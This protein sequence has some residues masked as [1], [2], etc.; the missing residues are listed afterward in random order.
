MTSSQRRDDR[1][2]P[3]PRRVAIVHALPLELYPPVTN[4]LDC[5]GTHGGLACEVFTSHNRAGRPA[6][7]SRHARIHR[8]PSLRT[9]AGPLA[10]LWTPLRFT[11][12]TT[13]ALIRFRPDAILYYEPHSA[14]PV[15]L[16]SRYV[17]PGARLLIHHHEYYEPDQFENPGMR[18][19][20]ASHRLEL[21][22]LFRKADWVSQTNIDRVALMQRDCPFL[23]PAVVHAL[24]NYPPREW[25]LRVAET[26]RPG[27]P[28][29]RCVHIGSVSLEDS[30]V[31]EMCAWIA[32]RQGAVTMD[33]Y[34]YKIPAR[35]RRFL[36]SAEERGWVRCFDTGVAYPDLPRVLAEYHVGLVLHRGNTINYA[37]NTP[38]KL[39]EYLAC[40]LDV[41]CPVDMPGVRT[42][43]RRHAPPRVTALDFSRMGEFDVEDAVSQGRTRA[44]M[45][46]YACENALAPLVA[47]LHGSSKITGR[48]ETP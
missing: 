23:D 31:R 41:W 10:R 43:L 8:F 1:I 16:Y 25:A 28:P 37:Y 11:L 20:K 24:P 9:G 6:Y 2:S 3:L 12:G 36:A 32:T 48:S 30:Y 26:P 5:L 17:D 13:R 15:F 38:N 27:R 45:Q 7:V 47:A 18:I 14:M 39:F 42:Y 29:L 40:G 19:V 35:T 21:T 4:L 34:D 44:C 22:H 33:V 46:D